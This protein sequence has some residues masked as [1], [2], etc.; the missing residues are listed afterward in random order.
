M[1]MNDDDIE[2]MK[3]LIRVQRQAIRVQEEVIAELKKVVES[4]K[5]SEALAEEVI[6]SKNDLIERMRWMDPLFGVVAR[7][8]RPR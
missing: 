2:A 8:G 5:R 4:N 1:A 3:D 7:Q 6:R